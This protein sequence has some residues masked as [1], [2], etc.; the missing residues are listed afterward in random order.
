VMGDNRDNSEDSRYWGFVKKEY[1]IGRAMMVYWST[2][3]ST[4]QTNLITS[5]F[6][7]ARW[8]RIMIPLK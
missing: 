5:F 7:R 6:T 3:E 1:V 4:P 2:D 8:K